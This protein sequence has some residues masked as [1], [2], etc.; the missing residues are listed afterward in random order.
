M[1]KQLLS[2]P[3]FLLATAIFASRVHAGDAAVAQPE[4]I[5]KTAAAF[6]AAFEKGDAKTVASFWTADG[7]Y[8][9][10][11]GRALKGRKAIEDD[12]TEFFAAN[13]GMKVRLDVGS[14]QLPTPDIAIEDGV[15]SVTMPDGSPP[16]RARYTNILVKQ[17][18]HW[19]LQSVRE[20]PYVPRNNYQHLRALEWAIGEWVDNG[21]NGQVAHVTFDWTPDLNFIISNRAVAVKDMFLDNGTQRIGWDPAAKL[22]HSWTFETDGGFGEGTW[23]QDGDKWTIKA[24]SVLQSGDQV[25]STN[26]VT[27][28]DADTITWQ[29]KD[30]TVN[31]KAIPDTA[32]ITM[33]RVK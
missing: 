5:H 33:K 12:F 6:I 22:L 16:S 3:G 26:V 4:E 30:V 17:D 7:D 11:S 25:I 27:R 8:I 19:L 29:A 2:I 28:V 21:P 18:G 15:S 32:V 24:S 23:T 31:G 1:K 9:D 13:K 20:A 10:Q 14:V